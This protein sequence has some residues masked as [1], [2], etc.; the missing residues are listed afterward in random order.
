ME[1]QQN[2]LCLPFSLH[3]FFLLAV[4][5]VQKKGHLL[6]NRNEERLSLCVLVHKCGGV[7]VCACVR[8][9][10][11][12][13]DGMGDIQC[14]PAQELFTVLKLSSDAYKIFSRLEGTSLE[15]AKPQT[16]MLGSKYSVTSS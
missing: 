3:V 6:P 16:D 4:T 14:V 1:H 15:G 11:T 7:R 5:A 13:W 12:R 10:C 2:S 8:G 9:T